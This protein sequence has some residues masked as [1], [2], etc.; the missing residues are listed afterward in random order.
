MSPRVIVGEAPGEREV[1][2]GR[3]FVGKA[4]RRLNSS[5]TAAGVDRLAVHITNTVLCRPVGNARPP[6]AAVSACHERLIT[7]IRMKMPQK[8]LALGKTAAEALTDD[9]R[10]IE[11]LRLVRPAPSPYLDE[12]T[13]VR[14]SYHPS[15]LN[16]NSKWRGHFDDDTG[17]LGEP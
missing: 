8:V 7:E 14:V 17:W 12:H 9:A 4:G 10:P 5:L 1:I 3:P 11:E 13:E 2:E 15:A 16:R 6:R